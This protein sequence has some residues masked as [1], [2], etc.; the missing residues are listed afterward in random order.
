[1]E[2]LIFNLNLDGKK[3]NFSKFSSIIIV[4]RRI[5]FIRATLWNAFVIPLF[6]IIETVVSHNFAER[7][8]EGK[9]WTLNQEIWASILESHYDQRGKLY[10][11]RKFWIYNDHFEVLSSLINLD[12]SKFDS[13]VLARETLWYLC[14]NHRNESWQLWMYFV[15]CSF[16]QFVDTSKNYRSVRN[17][18]V[19]INL[20]LS[21][22]IKK[23]YIFF[24]Q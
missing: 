8:R 10:L 12:W 1:M 19:R 23:K 20:L 7:E 17:E 5:R 14:C 9:L 11:F 15:F 16:L 4:K 6:R 2:I 18:N 3:A 22:D 21:C 24:I 13:L